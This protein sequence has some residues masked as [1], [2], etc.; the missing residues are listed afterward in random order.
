MTLSRPVLTCFRSGQAP[1][2]HAVY[3]RAAVSPGGISCLA[4][5]RFC[6]RQGLQRMEGARPIVLPLKCS[7]PQSGAT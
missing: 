5:S 4:V 7:W 6:V 3:M 2:N 1:I